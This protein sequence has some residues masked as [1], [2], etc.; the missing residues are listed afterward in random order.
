MMTG[1]GTIELA[2]EAMKKGAYD[3]VTKPFMLDE[4]IMVIERGLKQQAIKEE[5]IKLKEINKKLIETE[6]IKS[7]LINTISH[8]FKTP[9]TIIKG[10]IS[11]IL[12]GAMGNL[13]PPVEE[14][15][16]YIRQA[17]LKLEHLVTNLITLSLEEKEKMIIEKTDCIVE[18]IVRKVLN[19]F[20]DDMEEKFIV[21]EEHSNINKK[22]AFLDPGKISIAI[23]NLVDNAIK[24]NNN[25]GKIILKLD[26]PETKTLS[27]VVEDNGIGFPMEKMDCLISPFTQGDMSTT[28]SYGGTGLGL[29]VVKAIVEAHEGEL[30][31]ES[32]QNKG[33]N[34]QINI[35]NAF[36]D[37]K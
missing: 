20:R 7:D 26:A 28:R 8:E 24:F 16:K 23:R 12:S 6:K 11:M 1:F 25:E 36:L 30:I 9:I 22:V 37:K 3:F 32:V 5:N 34:F 33:S 15:L 35:P 14:G 17:S 21:S 29:A 4:I 27:I 19:E 31:I 18:E 13:N 10:Y 2:V